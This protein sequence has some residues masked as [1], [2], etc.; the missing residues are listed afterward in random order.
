VVD[1][2][3]FQKVVAEVEQE[4]LENLLVLLLVVIPLLL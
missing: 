1:Q 3:E 2:E 4:D